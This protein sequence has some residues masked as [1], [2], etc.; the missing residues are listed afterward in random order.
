MSKLNGWAGNILNVDLTTGKIE[1]EELSLNFAQ[2]YLGAC[3]FNAA[4]LFDLVEAKVDALSPEN[5]LMFGAGPLVGTLAP[6]CCRLTVTAKSPLTDI[7]GDSNMGGFFAPE[8]KYAGYDQIVIFGKSKQPSYLWIDDD[9]VELKDASHL[10][11]KSTWETAR[12][13]KEEAR[14]PDI[15]VLSIGQAGENLVRFANIISG[16]KRAAGRCGMGAV[17]GSKNLK[18]VAVRGTKDIMVARPEEF[19]EVCRE[20]YANIEK[21]PTRHVRSEFGTSSLMEIIAPTGRFGTKN[22]QSVFFEQVENITGERL[23]RDFSTGMRACFGCPV[24][25]TPFHNISSGEFVG[26]CGEGPEFGLTQLG[27][28]CGI[29]NLPALLKMNQLLNQ[30][31]MDC[32]S[33][34]GIIAW[35]MDCYD[36]G[37]LTEEDLDGISLRWGD[38]KSA[39]EII[40]RIA[41]REGVGDI[42]A[43]GEKRAPR[44][45][46]GSEKLMYHI[47]GLTP[48]LE[49]PRAGK[50]FGFMYYTSTR[51][52]DHLKGF[53]MNVAHLL[54]RGRGATDDPRSPEGKGAAVKG[55]E[56]LSTVIDASGMCKPTH[57]YMD[58][59]PHLLARLLSSATGIDFSGEQLLEIGERIYNVEKGFNSREGLTRKDDNLSVPEKFSQEPVKEGFY[60]GC[61]MEVDLMLDDYYKARGWD[62]Q[63]GLQARK[64]LE[65]L[66]LEGVATELEKFDA[67]R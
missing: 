64:K 51:G 7:F 46:E 19:I 3:G 41:K 50:L 49:D 66:G 65:E 33:M 36:R 63:T 48:V 15:Q 29:G 22:Y 23:K 21:N 34:Q 54:G 58:E 43:E 30:Y 13:I 37:I 1:K 20:A 14:D 39:I 8:M 57:R 17:M 62:L 5:I 56:D 9:V 28:R 6:S 27:P 42:L 67:I 61:V 11:G 59:S 16:S 24:H 10:W 12:M 2:K 18:A 47:K 40:H 26:V 4:K 52:A 31:G 53:P 60:K 55:N 32:V 35:A 25:C 44:L 38:Y 45:K